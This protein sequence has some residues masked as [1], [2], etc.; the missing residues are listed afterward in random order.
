MPSLLKTALAGHLDANGG[1]DL[2]LDEVYDVVC[3]WFT[4]EV[5]DF[6]GTPSHERRART[7]WQLARAYVEGTLTYRTNP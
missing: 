2:A 5:C 1:R 3:A 4:Y 6:N 7:C